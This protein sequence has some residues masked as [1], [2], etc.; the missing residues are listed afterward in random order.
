MLPAYCSKSVLL[1]GI[2]LY[3][4]AFCSLASH[5]QLIILLILAKL[6][7]PYG[8]VAIPRYVATRLDCR[9]I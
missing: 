7:Y 9:V 2:L 6:I 3:A 5:T 8:E 4:I 1:L